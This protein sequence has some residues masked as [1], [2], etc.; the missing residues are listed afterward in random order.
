MEKYMVKMVIQVKSQSDEDETNFD[1]NSEEICLLSF[2]MC[3]QYRN[4]I[5]ATMIGNKL[6]KWWISVVLE[7][8][9]QFLLRGLFLFWTLDLF[10][11]IKVW[12]DRRDQSSHFLNHFQKD[13]P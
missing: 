11:F 13:H 9:N 3:T 7:V 4:L 10:F 8:P 6:N 12:N 5:M 1:D 2:T